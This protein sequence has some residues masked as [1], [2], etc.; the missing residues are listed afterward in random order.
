[1]TKETVRLGAAPL[2]VEQVVAV[3]R[4]D[5]RVELAPE[6]LEAMAASRAIVDE[7][8]ADTRPHYG[9][10]TGFGA[11]ATQSIPRERRVQLQRSLVRSHAASSGP[12]V[13]REV[14]RATMLLR[15]A[16]LATGRTG[17][18]P[19]VARVYAAMLDAGITPVV[20]EY[21]SLGCSGDLAPL[22]HIALAAIGEGPVRVDGELLDAS[23]ALRGAGIEPL[24]LHEKE[25][26]ALINGTDGMLGMLCLA[27]HD[28]ERLLTTADL[29]AAMSI[30]GLAGTDAVFA[31]DL[32]ALRPHPGQAASARVMR[33]VLAGSPVVAAHR[34]NGFPRVQDAYSLRCAPQ[35]HG[36]A[37][38][39]VAHARRVAEIELASA[40]D[41]PVVTVDGR[42]ESN[43]NFHGAPLGY[44]LDFLA[45]AVADVAS[46][47]E[48]RTDRFLDRSRNHGLPPFLADDPGVDS[49]HMIAQYTQAGIVSELKRLAA[50]ASVDSIPTSAMQEDHVSMG[51]SAARKLRR[52][53]DGLG[54]VLAIELL[55]AARGVELRG[56]GCAPATERAVATLR[57][58]VPGAGP[59]RFL[60]PDI[61]AAVDLVAAGDLVKGLDA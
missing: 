1:M 11:L 50:P 28:L 58:R 55:T 14:V 43:G 41:N 38:D 9:I 39:T 57:E 56:E 37:R 44:V 61:A 26:L 5:A 49:G 51:W 19:E 18:R 3:A 20:G 47:S 24:E 33:Q 32:Q 4:H 7:L 21:G 46:M 40:I 12:E 27:L 22:A 34:T 2:T 54:R 17:A 23:A 60:A 36:A 25:G 6:A 15:L 10:S 48:R 8:A 29:A 31:E 59:D 52:S 53:L 30:E 13:E 16:T 42:I 45:I 35:V